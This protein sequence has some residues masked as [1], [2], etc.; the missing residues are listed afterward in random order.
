MH[1]L[2]RRLVAASSSSSWAPAIARHVGG[3][4]DSS[5]ERNDSDSLELLVADAIENDDED[6]DD[7]ERMVDDDCNLW[8]DDW[9]HEM[10][11]VSGDKR[12]GG[13]DVC[14]PPTLAFVACDAC[15]RPVRLML[16]VLRRR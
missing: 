3:S 13:G 15:R 14:A 4:R 5:A 6:A 1:W 8:I 11:S 16:I 9:E 7:A 10:Q 2:Q 12:S